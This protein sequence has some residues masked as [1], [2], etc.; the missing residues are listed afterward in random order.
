MIGEWKILEKDATWTGKFN[1]L[2]WRHGPWICIK[3]GVSKTFMY[4]NNV[5][6]ETEK[7]SN[8]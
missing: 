5:C 6:N 2:N 8:E 3:S 1:S 4:S 7:A